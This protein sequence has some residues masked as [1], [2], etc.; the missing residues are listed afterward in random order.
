MY[1]DPSGQFGV[2]T[3]IFAGTVL[4]GALLFSGCAKNSSNEIY[5]NVI[6]SPPAETEPQSLMPIPEPPDPIEKMTDEEIKAQLAVAQTI[7]GEAG[8]S[9][10]YP[11]EWKQGQE[12][13]AW[14]II[15]RVQSSKYPDNPLQVVTAELQ[16]T[17][18]TAGKKIY[19]AGAY[20]EES[21]QYAYTLAGYIVKCD[22][23]NIPYPTGFTDDHFEFRAE[24]AQ[25]HRAM[26]RI[27]MVTY[28]GNTFFATG[29]GR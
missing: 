24:V 1:V 21:W 17:G 18:Y 28:G 15:N 27:G 23:Y 11:N 22:Y 7:Y 9:K 4:V 13:V 3:S 19:E 26:G 20:D 2:L 8:G 12:A 6:F 25:D 29:G 10:R 5:D 16:F 14:T